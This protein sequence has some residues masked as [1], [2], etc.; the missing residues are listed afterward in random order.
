MADDELT[1]ISG[2][3]ASK[4]ELLREHG[5]EDIESIRAASQEELSDIDGIGNALAARIKADVDDVEVEE[6]DVPTDEAVDADEP[7]DEV[8]SDEAEPA[9]EDPDGEEDEAVGPQELTDISGVGESKAEL[10]REAGYDDLEAVQMASQEELADIDGIGNALA[11][12]I[13]A[14]LDTLEVEEVEEPEEDEPDEDVET[15]R[16]PIGHVDKTPTL[17]DREEELLQERNGTPQPAFNRYEQHMKKRVP[18]SWRAPRGGLSKQRRR[19]KGKGPVVEAGYRG[20]KAVRG[21][22]PSGFEEILVERPE[23]LDDVDGDREAVRIASGVGGR[24]RER[25]EEAAE[26]QE[27]R[28]LNPTYVEVEVTEE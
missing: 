8:E 24:K 10:L 11:A 12:R 13:K 18:T 1:E 9:D 14:D 17:S 23:D 2:V 7:E 21:R 5:F 16:R 27:I 26:D 6:S 20:P 22:H 3:G 15:E 28:V 25:I 19:I 4:A